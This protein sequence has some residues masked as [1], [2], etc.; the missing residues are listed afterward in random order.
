M[1]LWAKA[2]RFLFGITMQTTVHSIAIYGGGTGPGFPV[3]GPLLLLL[4]GGCLAFY[5]YKRWRSAEKHL[6]NES[7]QRM[8]KEV[9]LVQEGS[10]TIVLPVT[11]I[12]YIFRCGK[13]TLARTFEKEDFLISAT[14]TDLRQQL[15]G[16]K[17]FRANRQ[18]IVS[19][20]TCKYYERRP[21]G[22]LQLFVLP[23]SKDAMI[24][25]QKRAK[26]FKK[27]LAAGN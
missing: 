6:A 21:F 23:P 11:A 19:F 8:V 24:I 16:R 4:G 25:S 1:R 2:A 9:L 27:W 13:Y 12:A 18:A 17:F 14:L 15:N 7:A 3:T 5:F 10:K 26:A 20:A 22:K